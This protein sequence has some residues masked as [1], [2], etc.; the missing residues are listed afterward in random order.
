MSTAI[1]LPN[2][3]RTAAQ[4]AAI[5]ALEIKYEFLKY[6]RLPIYAV[7]TMV[8]P[9][10]FYVLFGLLMNRGGNAG[11]VTVQSYLIATYGTFGVMGASLFANGA[12]VAVERG[13]GWL[14]VK[15]ASPMPPFAYFVA[16]FAVGM[17]FS[18][19]VV[20][21][22]LTLGTLFGGVRFSALD[23][24]RLTG[25][26]VIGSLPFCAMGLAIGSFAGP[27]SA[28]AIVNVFYLPLSF[29]SGLWVPINFLP[30]FLQHTAKFLP[31]Y[32]LAQ[33][34]LG[35]V[36]G[37]PLAP[38]LYDWEFLA[39]FTLV[40]LGIARIGFQRDEGKTYG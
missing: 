28:P 14:Q 15:R 17:A 20:L 32:H 34:A 26:L 31:P 8:F 40:A 6:L 29:A 24:A 16:K 12:G 7:S 5:F 10:M 22:L 21:A 18:L 27:N 23:A 39:G 3:T 13:L 19:I 1:T 11:G 38:R 33:L 35:I 2:P 30:Q 4:S 36:A 37:T 9:I 25:T